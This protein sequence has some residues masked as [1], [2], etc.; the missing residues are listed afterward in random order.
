[1]ILQGQIYQ[2]LLQKPTSCTNLF[3]LKLLNKAWA[4]LNHLSC[5]K[6][7]FFRAQWLPIKNSNLQKGF[8]YSSLFRLL[9]NSVGLNIIF[10]LL[11]FTQF[12]Q[13]YRSNK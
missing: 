13:S 10:F 9:E 11:C 3:Y 12:L 2:W 4:A 6:K 8:Q 7:F 5:K 1:V